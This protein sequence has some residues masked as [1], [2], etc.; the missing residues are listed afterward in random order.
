MKIKSACACRTDKQLIHQYFNKGQVDFYQCEGCGVVFRYPMPTDNELSE[1]YS[2]LYNE[3]SIVNHMTNQESSDHAINQYYLYFEKL[4]KNK[5]L[6]LLDYGC[7]TGAMV[8]KL[9]NLGISAYGVESSREARTFAMKEK[10]LLLYESLTSFADNSIDIVTLIEVIEHLPDPLSVILD[11]YNK[12]R[13]R[14]VIFITTPN[15]KGARALLE[16]GDWREAQKRFHVVF[17][18]KKSLTKLL[19]NAGFS[20]IEFVR[21]SPLQRSGFLRAIFFRFLQTFGL[22][23][24]LCIRAV[25]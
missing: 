18:T 20:K 21:Y 1:I 13:P 3:S 7:G 10:Q 15:L 12:I 16:R 5:N 9:K 8:Q 25:K 6:S 14:G 23:G 11:I 19:I 22:S 17:F 24:T 2:N 4:I